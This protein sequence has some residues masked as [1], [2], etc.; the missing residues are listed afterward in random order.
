MGKLQHDNKSGNST[1]EENDWVQFFRDMW[2]TPLG[3][4]GI[5]ITTICISLMLFALALDFLGLVQNPYFAILSYM[6]LPAG[7]V[8]GLL[9][10]PL[11]GYMRRRHWFKSSLAAEQ[12]QIN[13]SSPRHRRLLVGF[14]AIS[15]INLMI[16]L[17]YL[18]T[19]PLA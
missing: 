13:L 3:L 17:G 19:V 12:L 2:N 5:T 4:L 16:L 1:Q 9:I 11:G 15:S 8:F 14:L 7:M 10:I 6:V 18:R